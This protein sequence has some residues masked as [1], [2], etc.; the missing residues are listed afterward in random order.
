MKDLFLQKKIHTL[1]TG[2]SHEAVM[3]TATADTAA[4]IFFISFISFFLL[5]S[6]NLTSSSDYLRDVK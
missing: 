5:A 3:T 1:G 4:I 2:G 6:Q